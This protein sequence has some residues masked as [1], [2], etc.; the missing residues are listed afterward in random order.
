V[1]VESAADRALFV[2]ADEF[3]IAATIGVTTVNGIFD[4]EYIEALG[5]SSVKPIFLCLATE[6][7]TVGST[8][9][10]D[11]DAYTIQNVEPDGTGFKLLILE[12]Q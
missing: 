11:G 1:A 3:G 4:R 2:D 5:Y 10:I 6:T 12:K 9:T 8:I 7:T